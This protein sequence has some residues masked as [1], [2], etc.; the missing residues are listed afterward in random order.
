MLRGSLTIATVGGIP[1]RI[2]WTFGVLLAWISTS[3]ALHGGTASKGRTSAAFTLAVFLCVMLHEL[4][5]ALADR[6]HRRTG[7][8]KAGRERRLRD[9]ARAMERG[10]LQ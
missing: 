5:H 4:G 10:S 3:G 1:I 7:F 9:R 8:S 2:H 6:K